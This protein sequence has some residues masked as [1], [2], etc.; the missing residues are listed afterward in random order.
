MSTAIRSTKPRAKVEKLNVRVTTAQK[1]LVLKAA[2]ANGQSATDYVVDS[3]LERLARDVET[4][5]AITMAPG[6]REVLMA[7]SMKKTTL[8]A[9]WYRAWAR[10]A[11]IPTV[12]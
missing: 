12:S 6:D 1:R 7:I 11:S 8:P 2:K 4:T 5:S 10:A 3:V 9:S